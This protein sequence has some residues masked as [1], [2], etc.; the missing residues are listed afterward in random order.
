[1]RRRRG[2]GILLA[3]LVALASTLAGCGA[4]AAPVRPA[5]AV[6]PSAATPSTVPTILVTAAHVKDNLARSIVIDA[7]SV[8]DYTAGH[9]AGAINARWQRF[10][11]A[12]TGN[13]GDA[14]WGTLRTADEIAAG[15]GSLGIQRDKQIVVYASPDNPG[16]DGRIVWMLRMAGFPNSMIL[17]GGYKAWTDA[18][19][20]TSTDPTTLAP[21]PVSIRSLDQSMRITTTQLSAHLGDVKLVDVRTEKEFAGATD[22]GEA[23][24]G[25]LPGAVNVPVSGSSFGT[26]AAFVLPEGPVVLDAADADEAARAARALHAVGLFELAGWRAGG[27]AETVEPVTIDELERRELQMTELLTHQATLED[28]FLHL[29]GRHLRDT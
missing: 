20:P 22:S 2:L 9:I 24:G 25:H 8:A 29:T 10:S 21:V 19:Y 6:S 1:M 12:E 17:D 5:G 14:G 7:R 27:G 11:N 18:G 3:G 28:L 13:P 26:K 4:P 16:A 23:R 15:L